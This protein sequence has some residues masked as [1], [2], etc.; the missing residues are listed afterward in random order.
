MKGLDDFFNLGFS[1]ILSIILLLFLDMDLED[2]GR[3]VDD[4]LEICEEDLEDCVVGLDSILGPAL[5]SILGPALDSGLDSVLGSA[6]GSGLERLFVILL[7]AF[8]REL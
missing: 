2:N 7:L 3:G 6:L 8:D 4:V 1:D 5:G